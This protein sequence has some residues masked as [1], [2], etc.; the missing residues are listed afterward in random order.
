M[1]L[2]GYQLKDLNGS[3]PLHLSLTHN[4]VNLALMLLEKGATPDVCDDTGLTP[5]H[6]AA[7][8]GSVQL[9][10]ALFAAVPKDKLAKVRTL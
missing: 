6:L 1:E 9:I 4:H 8:T 2:S 10:D 7:E 3:T 5:L